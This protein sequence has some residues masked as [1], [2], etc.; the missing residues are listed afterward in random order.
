M[1]ASSFA[2]TRCQAEIGRARPTTAGGVQVIPARGV[3]AVETEGTR[4]DTGE[5]VVV[6]ALC[7]HNCGVWL[8]LP[9]ARLRLF[10]DAA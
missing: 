1:S 3:L 8:P 9:N 5:K 2:C 10:V 6:V 7:C 4:H